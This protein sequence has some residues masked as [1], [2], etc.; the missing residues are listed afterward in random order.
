MIKVHELIGPL[1]SI[2]CDLERLYGES[3]EADISSHPLLYQLAMKSI[4]DSLQEVVDRIVKNGC[5]PP[6]NSHK[7][8]KHDD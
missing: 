3:S 1:T 7:P 4:S 6:G 8:G 5:D 2:R